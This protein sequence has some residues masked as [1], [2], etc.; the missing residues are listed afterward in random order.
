MEQGM[1]GLQAPGSRPLASISGVRPGVRPSASSGRPEHVEGRSPKPEAPE[2]LSIEARRDLD[3]GP[4]DALALETIIATRP[5]VGVFLSKAWLAGFSPSRPTAPN[6]FCC[7]CVKEGCC[8][9]SCPL[10]SREP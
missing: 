4:E 10:R 8:V 9:A 7:S 2:R 3:L 1:M 6:R 5:Y